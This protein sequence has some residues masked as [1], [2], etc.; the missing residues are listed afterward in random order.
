MS[1]AESH[2]AVVG[3]SCRLPG[4]DDAVAFWRQL[5]AGVESIERFDAEALRAA[6]VA[7]ER[8]AD[9]DYVPCRGRVKGLEDFD[10][11]FFGLS[12]RDASRMDP[13]HR[14]FLQ[15]AWHA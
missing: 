6:G 15:C 5:R 12:P 1:E 9:P 3:L 4:S 8:T 13:Q 11:D 7:A 14:A 10:A 2:L